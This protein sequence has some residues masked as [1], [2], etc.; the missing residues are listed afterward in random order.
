MT[1]LEQTILALCTCVGAFIGASGLAHA[2]SERVAHFDSVGAGSHRY[3]CPERS[4]Q[5]ANSITSASAYVSS[6]SSGEYVK[7][8]ASSMNGSPVEF[9]DC[10]ASVSFSSS[11]RRA[12]IGSSEAET[13]QE[14]GSMGKYVLYYS[15]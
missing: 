2:W 10:S 11:T 3:P 13:W 4:G 8:C 15:G 14:A 7:A 1:R 6:Y 5:D 12:D 9:T